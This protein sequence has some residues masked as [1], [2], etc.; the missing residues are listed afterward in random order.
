MVCPD[1]L[2][3]HTWRE[4]HRESQGQRDN[5]DQSTGEDL[6]RISQKTVP[7]VLM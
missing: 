6:L 2:E 1:G 5:L 3:T 7:R 4:T